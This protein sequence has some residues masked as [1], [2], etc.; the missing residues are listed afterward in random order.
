M[1]R[2]TR[3][4]E[5]KPLDEFGRDR[6]QADGHQSQCKPC[7]TAKLREWR[8]A[9][10]D[11]AREIER[12]RRARH[13]EK[14]REAQRRWRAANPN[15]VRELNRRWQKANLGK[16]AQ[17]NAAW[18]VAHQDKVRAKRARTLARSKAR[19]F[20]H[21][22]TICACCGSADDL[23][24][25]HVDGYQSDGSAGPR[26]GSELYR[27]LVN[28]NFPDGF[29]TLCRPCNRNKASGPRCTLAHQGKSAAA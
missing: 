14:T 23:Q 12:R 9:N 25:D 15:R 22:G 27:W 1:K 2:C 10:P 13:P 6:H 3:C 4:G 20:A 8:A 17:S 21:Y 24:I 28:N 16:V 11:K 26:S 5:V 7:A 29:Q 18:D 19:V